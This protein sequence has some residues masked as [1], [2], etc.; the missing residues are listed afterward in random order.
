VG[1][2]P[3]APTISSL[4]IEPGGQ[5]DKPQPAEICVPSSDTALPETII[6]AR[7]V[8]RRFRAE[9]A[10]TFHRILS[11]PAAM[12]YWSTPP[13]R[14]YAET[15]AWI[16]KTIAA[17]AGGE[18]DDFIALHEGQIVGKAGL[19]SGNEIGMIFAS[20]CWGRGFAGEAVTAII[21][22]AFARGLPSIKADV[23]PRNERSLKLLGR[24]GFVESGRA[25]RTLQ[26]G[27]EWV[28]S[29]YLELKAPARS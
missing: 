5:R 10:Q 18:A 17:V 24:L 14:T 27:D 12:G 26:V 21:A 29:V 9:D 2:N 3:A 15:E 11:D 8:L 20:D 7:L 19:W 28:D 16:A 25:K 1:S 13:H 6:T 22:R 23:D 4:F